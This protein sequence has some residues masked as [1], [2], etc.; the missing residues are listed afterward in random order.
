MKL[1]D[2]TVVVG[3]FNLVYAAIHGLA[4]SSNEGRRVL[5]VPDQGTATGTRSKS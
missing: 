5:A 3:V 4:A 1:N 2:K